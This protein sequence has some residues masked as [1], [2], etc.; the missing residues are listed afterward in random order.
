MLIDR[1]KRQGKSQANLL[2]LISSYLFMPHLYDFVQTNVINIIHSIS[3]IVLQYIDIV[4]A[5]MYTCHAKHM[6]FQL[7]LAYTYS[8]PKYSKIN[9]LLAMNLEMV[10]VWG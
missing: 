2:V 6:D 8:V 4:S 3:F 9:D 1:D 5:F 10:F 7:A